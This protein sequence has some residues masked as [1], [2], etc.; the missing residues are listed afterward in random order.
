M[1]V[2]RGEIANIL[3]VQPGTVDAWV[4]SGMPIEDRPGQGRP[5]VFETAACIGW[6]ITRETA[7][8]IDAAERQAD[9]AELDALRARRIELQNE[10]AA[11]DLAVAKGEVAPIEELAAVFGRRTLAAR[12]YLMHQMP[13]RIARALEMNSRGNAFEIIRDEVRAALVDFSTAN[14]VNA[15]AEAGHRITERQIFA[16]GQCQEVAAAIDAYAGDEGAEAAD[17]A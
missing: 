15:F 11:M 13:L 12:G 4:A 16:C 7:K 14:V 1:K 6:M 3:G 8:A 10:K 17:A 5:A 2:N 9:P